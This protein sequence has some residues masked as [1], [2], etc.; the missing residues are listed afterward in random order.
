MRRLYTTFPGGWP[1]LGL[2][3]LRVATGVTLIVQSMAALASLRDGGIA[4]LALYLLAIGSGGWLL[5]GLLT[6][7]SCTVAAL[8]GLGIT[9]L[10]FPKASSNFLDGNLLSF[11]VIIM[12]LSCTLIGPGAFSLDAHFFGRRKIVIPRSA[13]SQAPLSSASHA[14]TSSPSSPPASRPST[15]SA[16]RPPQL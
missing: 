7:I 15:S 3:L 6:P 8:S 10:R 12:A 5:L 9:L 13:H 2:L 1:G 14:P 11:D 16:A 4:T